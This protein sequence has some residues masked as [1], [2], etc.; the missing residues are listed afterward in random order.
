[1]FHLSASCRRNERCAMGS[2]AKEYSLMVTSSERVRAMI[3]I[4]NDVM[5]SD[6]N[7]AKNVLNRE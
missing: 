7:S 3:G 5:K 6:A 1:M 4:Y 2:E